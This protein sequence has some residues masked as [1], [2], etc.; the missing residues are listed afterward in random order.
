MAAPATALRHWRVERR[1]ERGRYDIVVGRRVQY[2]VIRGLLSATT[3]QTVE[4]IE[5]PV[6]RAI[7]K[8]DLY[9]WACAGGGAHCRADERGRRY[10]GGS[11]FQ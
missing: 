7:P 3:P 9:H 11:M 8:A 10:R 4:F 5:L 1:G 2:C 6:K